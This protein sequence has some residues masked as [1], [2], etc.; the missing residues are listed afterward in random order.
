MADKEKVPAAML[1][2]LANL[3]LQAR[4]ELA[5]ALSQVSETFTDVPDGKA[6]AHTLGVIARLIDPPG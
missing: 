4:Q 2:E 6:T 1:D 3:D 5:T